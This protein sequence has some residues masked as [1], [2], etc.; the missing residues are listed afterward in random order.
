M[1][2]KFLLA[3]RSQRPDAQVTKFRS[4]SGRRRDKGC[5]RQAAGS[6]R[7]P[8]TARR[9]KDGGVV[10]GIVSGVI[11]GAFTKLSRVK[12]GDRWPCLLKLND[13]VKALYFVDFGVKFCLH[14]HGL[15]RDSA[16]ECCDVERR[17]LLEG[18]YGRRIGN[19]ET[20]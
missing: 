7:L 18:R 9:C 1:N 8:S 13:V 19:A 16:V 3:A 20:A 14:L 5:A 6:G 12:R 2:E 11:L 10:S 4:K 15:L 17:V